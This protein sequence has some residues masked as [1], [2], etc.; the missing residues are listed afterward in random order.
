MKETNISQMTRL[1]L[2]KA[3][4]IVWRNNTGGLYDA[5][6]R[7]VSFGLAPGSA[8]LIGIYKGLFLSIEIKTPDEHKYILNH[9]EKILAGDWGKK[10]KRAR[11]KK[12]IKWHDIVRKSGGIAFFLSNPIIAVDILIKQYDNIIKLN[13][14]RAKN[15]DNKTS[16]A[17]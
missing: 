8:D 1:N 16:P 15:D 6:G 9:W 5:N 7:W 14:Q 11:Y 10:D 17:G 13:K 12:Q 3:G 4:A 2:A